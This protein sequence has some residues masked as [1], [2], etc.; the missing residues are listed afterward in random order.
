MH[1][2]GNGVARKL[3]LF[4]RHVHTVGEVAL[5]ERMAHSLE[6][7]AVSKIDVDDL[8]GF[9]GSGLELPTLDGGDRGLS[10][11]GCPPVHS[12]LRTEPLGAI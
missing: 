9:F 3:G 8:N 12:T 1:G 10:Q 4:P 7:S 2:S 6:E 11:S 5:A